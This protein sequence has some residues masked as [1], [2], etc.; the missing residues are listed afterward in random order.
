MNSIV[1]KGEDVFDVKKGERIVAADVSKEVAQRKL[2]NLNCQDKNKVRLDKVKAH[3]E[4]MKSAVT[5][6][7]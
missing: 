5:R 3:Q 4:K 1:A 2:K 7:A 6:T